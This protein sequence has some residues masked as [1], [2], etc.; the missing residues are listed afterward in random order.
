[1]LAHQDDALDHFVAGCSSRRSPAAATIRPRR[2]PTL[3]T[4]IGV[5]LLVASTMLP[6][7]VERMD[8]ADAAHVERLLAHVEVVAAGVGVGVLNRAITWESGIA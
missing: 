6:D 1:M 4:L 3:E 8:Q 7:V 2:Q 5:D